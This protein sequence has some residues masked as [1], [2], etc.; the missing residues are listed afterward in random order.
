MGHLKIDFHEYPKTVAPDDFWGQVGRTVH[1]KP[2]SEQQIGMIVD[3]IKSG[4][5]LRKNDCMLDIACGNGALSNLLFAACGELF[6][7]DFSE[8]LISIAKKNFAKPPVFDFAVSGAA[9][10]VRAEMAPERFT[11]AL[12]YGSFAY[13]SFD[14][15]SATLSGLA[16]RFPNIRTVYI[17]NLPDRDLAHLFYKDGRDYEKELSDNTAQIGI[18]RSRKEFEQLAAATGWSAQFHT[19]P[20]DFYSAHYRYDAILERKS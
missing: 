17:G 12:C 3:A 5:D 11:K 8:Y 20:S 19:M 10:Y 14:D 6:G 18:W 4:L 2:V 13:F 15:A 7:C 16:M 9:E 1:G